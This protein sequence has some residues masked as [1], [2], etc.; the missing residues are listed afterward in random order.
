[1]ILSD[2]VNNIS[3]D[4]NVNATVTTV[5]NRILREINRV[6]SEIWNGFRWSF[7]FRNY[8]I[9]TDTDVTAGTVT[10]TN[11]SR[12]ITG[13]GTAFLSSN[14]TWHIYFPQDSVANWYRVRR[15]TS[16][17]QLELDVPYQ[18]TSGTTRTY[19]MRHFDYVLPTEPWDLASIV[20]TNDNRI[21]P[22]IEGSSMDLIG[23]VPF[24]KGYPLAVSIY[25]SDSQPTTYSTGTVSGTINTQT[26]TGVGTSWLAN[27]YPGDKVTIG[28]YS[29]TVYSV[30]TDTQIILY[31][32]QQITSTTATY[33]ITRQFGRVMRIL[34]PSTDNYTLDLR[35]MRI[36]PNLVNSSDT[37][38]ILYRFPQVISLK[39]SALELK[40][41]N[42]VRSRVLEADAETALSK[43]KAEDDAMTPRKA[44]API[45]SYRSL[46]RN[47]NRDSYR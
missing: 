6:G 27:I 15:Y 2:L 28:S 3:D 7:R 5:Y 29:Y 39:V 34:W 36:Y 30:D 20:V 45:Y 9:V 23:P 33:T 24:Y 11:G 21:V 40:S 22:I 35:A 44:I 46:R 8:R 37:N 43:A 4:A 17:T 19:I 16:P 31:N 41:Q 14:A 1:M 13:S 12:T 32:S 47:I 42:D 26:L 10:L 18:G 25:G 38:E